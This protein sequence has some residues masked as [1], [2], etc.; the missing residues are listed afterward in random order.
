MVASDKRRRAIVLSLLAMVVCV[1]M[2]VSGHPCNEMKGKIEELLL[3]MISACVMI[4][5]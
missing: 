5:I 1:F 4:Y 2:K 3:V